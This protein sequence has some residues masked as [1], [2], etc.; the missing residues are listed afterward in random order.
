VF[1]LEYLFNYFISARKA[2]RPVFLPIYCTV[3]EK[4]KYGKR[5][6]EFVSAGIP[7]NK[8]I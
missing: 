6:I 1:F 4:M 8:I 2:S 5:Y 7:C 3:P